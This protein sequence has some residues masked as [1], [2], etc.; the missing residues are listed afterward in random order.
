MAGPGGSVTGAEFLP[1]VTSVA[2]A[3][4]CLGS[5]PSAGCV[6]LGRFLNLRLLTC[7]TG[8]MILPTSQGCCD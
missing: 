6:T 3:A 2:F 1:T 5:N 7:R 4:G 8:V